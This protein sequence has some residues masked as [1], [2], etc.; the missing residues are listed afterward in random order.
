[1]PNRNKIPSDIQVVIAL[2]LLTCIFITVP[3]LSHTPIRTVL[4]LPMVLF[5]PGYALIAALFPSR[6]DLDGI[7]RLALSFG[8]SIAVVPLI[9]LALNYTPWGI[10]LLP[11]LISLSAFTILMCAVAVLRRGSLP[12][13][14]KFSVPFSSAYASIKEEVSGKPENKL[15]RILTILLVISILASVVTLAYVVVTPKEGEKFTE[16]YVLGPEGMADGYPTEL[17]N[18]Q[19]GN[20]I[21]GIVNHE[22]ADTEYSIELV[23]G[24]N[25][26][27]MGQELQHITLQHNQT[28]EKEVTFTP[29][30][31][32][33][34]MKLQFLL[35]KDN[36][37][38]EP[39]R[40]LHLWIDV[41]ES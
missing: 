19:S 14:D 10:R 41:G 39:Y 5:L 33:D 20:V 4:G 29:E 9:G 35:Y 31:V 38:T 2:V 22:Y 24:N 11:I 28:W 6:D 21:I 3:D 34:D 13:D 26:I 32:G 40:D 8:L 23:L 17:R 36:N 18:G 15:D 25:S 37:M 16:F 7:E 27:P 30:S 1:M 12:V